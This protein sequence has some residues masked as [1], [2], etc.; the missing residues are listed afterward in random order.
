[1]KV[2]T[3]A[4]GYTFLFA[5]VMVIVVAALLSFTAMSLQERQAANVEQEKMQNI[6]ASIGVEVE[7]SEA[8]DRYAEVITE[9]RILSGGQ[10]V[11]S[12]GVSAFDINMADELKKPIEDRMLPLYVA[13]NKGSRSY[14][15]PLRGKGLWGPIWGY[16]ALKEDLS[17]VIGATFGHKSETPGL[18]AEI[19]TPIF[20][21]QFPGKEIMSQGSFVS[22]E[23]RK[24]DASGAHQVDGIS[25]GTITSV[26]VD[27]M[28]K[29]CLK[30]YTSYFDHLRGGG[31]A[32]AGTATDNTI[33][34]R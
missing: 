2:N 28:L 11:E 23:V 1:M 25:G 30:G 8:A 4:N 5:S 16:I 27:D 12:A 34:N 29:D 24:G 13:D 17:T 6:L 18:G 20:Q 33:A 21:D 3:N 32:D 31:M 14:I 19:S 15:I 22:I 7:R 10:R 26:G 9:E